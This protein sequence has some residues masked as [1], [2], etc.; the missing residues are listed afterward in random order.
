MDILK[1]SNAKALAKTRYFT[2]KPCPYNH[3]CERMTSSGHCVKCLS[4][5]SMERQK[6]KYASDPEYRQKV[7]AR[8][9]KY[10][11]ENRE[12]FN[13]YQAKYVE[14]NRAH[15]RSLTRKNYHSNLPLTKAKAH[16]RRALRR[17]KTS[18]HFTAEDINKLLVLQ[19][20]KC[21]TCLKYLDKY[22]IDHIMPLSK[23]GTNAKENIQLLCKGCNRRKSS[24]LPEV[25]AAMN[26]LLI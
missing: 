9:K 22:E 26:G 8:C 10:V 2:G 6:K 3:I 11:R 13:A 23:G 5:R 24:R 7:L 25:W 15:L 1:R 19:K 18:G 12:K 20:C 4:R 21:I 14:K 17:D 16:K